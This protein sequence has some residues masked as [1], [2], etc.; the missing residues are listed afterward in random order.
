MN[1]IITAFT[2]SLIAGLSTMI[3]CLF[4]YLKPKKISNFIG[5]SLS[6]S[7][8]I[9]LLISITDLIPEGFFYISKNY[10]LII[11]IIILLLMI[12][13]GNKVNSVI[14]KKIQKKSKESLYK[15]GIL[16]MLALIIHNMPEGVL[17][18]LSSTIDI[19]M[20]IKYGL[21]IMLHNIPEGIAIAIPIYYSTR[22]KIKAIKFTLIS[23]ISE[24]LGALLAYL[25]LYKYISNLMISIILLF[26]A[27]LMISISIND[28]FKESQKYSKKSLIKGLIIGII[29]IILTNIF[30][31]FTISYKI[32][33]NLIQSHFL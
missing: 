33:N 13:I 21:A 24:P 7:A 30:L 8:T 12:L 10:N 28:I 5:I 32:L 1:N 16:N 27:G 19:K 25:I 20:G 11:A 6:F 26:T 22:N 29:V 15:L 9:M 3:G 18:F 4:I 31:W 23:A 2:V 14:D 17:T